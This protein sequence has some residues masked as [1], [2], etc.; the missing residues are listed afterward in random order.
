MSSN[1]NRGVRYTD[2]EKALIGALIN[3]VGQTG[4][5]RVM[6]RGGLTPATAVTLGKIAREYGIELERGRRAMEKQKSYSLQ[7]I[8]DAG[9]DIAEFNSYERVFLAELVLWR[10]VRGTQVVMKEFGVTPASQNEL[11]TIF[12]VVKPKSN[13]VKPKKAVKTSKKVKPKKAV[14][15]SKKVVASKG[16]RY[17]N[18]EKAY[19]AAL[20]EV[21]GLTHTIRVLSEEYKVECPSIMTLGKIAKEH[22]VS[23]SRGRSAA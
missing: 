16:S 8:K 21:Y 22:K 3:Q 13:V 1:T 19:L 9:A 14:K 7:E 17:T 5:Q 4:V 11:A 18:R 15:T 12:H 20:V 6:E 10:G 23:L 2:Y